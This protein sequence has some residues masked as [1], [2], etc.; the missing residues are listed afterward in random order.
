[1][2]DGSKCTEQW[3]EQAVAKQLYFGKGYQSYVAGGS[4]VIYFAN[5][6]QTGPVFIASFDLST[7]SIGKLK[8]MPTD[9][10][11]YCHCGY[12]PVSVVIGTTLYTMGNYGTKYQSGVWSTL[13]KYVDPMRRGE[14]SGAVSGNDI[15]LI[16]G[17]GGTNGDYQATVLAFDT[18]TETFEPASTHPDYPW[19]TLRT[20]ATAEVGAKIYVMGGS[21]NGNDLNRAAV[22]DTTARKWEK[23]PDVPSGAFDPDAAAL[24]GKNIFY[25]NGQAVWRFEIATN[26]WAPTSFTL[27]V[28]GSNWRMVAA[29]SGVYALGDYADGI[30][31]FR[32]NAY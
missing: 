9:A 20:G 2:G 3:V 7:K 5:G 31:I 23:L 10:N 14:A 27:P 8:L 13:A 24:A 12:G 22:Y 29:G 15:F 17:R 11:N 32:L 25:T 30:H 4:T 19:G 26:A 21:V 6:P 18:K 16:G 28:N 1:V